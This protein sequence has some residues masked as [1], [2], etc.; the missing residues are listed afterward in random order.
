MHGQVFVSLRICPESNEK[1]PNSPKALQ[2][3]MPGRADTYCTS[4]ADSHKPNERAR[5]AY[6]ASRPREFDRNA[7]QQ[8]LSEGRGLRP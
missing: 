1:A 4:F 3:A 8:H 2:M 7:E 5:Q 6:W